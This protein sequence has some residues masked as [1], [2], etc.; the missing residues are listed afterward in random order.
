MS[1]ESETPG[2]WGTRLGTRKRWRSPSCALVGGRL[3]LNRGSYRM[4]SAGILPNK[5]PR[6]EIKDG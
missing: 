4:P 1:T 3:T 2:S 6:L 5:T